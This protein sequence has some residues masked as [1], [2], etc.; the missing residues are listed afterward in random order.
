[1]F[2]LNVLERGVRGIF[3]REFITRQKRAHYTKFCSIVDSD[4]QEEK[5]NMISTLPQLEELKDE[6][7]LSG[8]SEYSYTLANKVYANGVRIPR[9]AIEFDQTGQLR[10]LIQSLAA[11]VANFPDKLVFDLLKN[12][13]SGTCYD[14]TAFFG[15]S[16]DLGDG[17]SQ[18]NLI[19]ANATTDLL[20]ASANSSKADWENALAMVMTDLTRARQALLTL[21]DD[22]GEPWHD[23]LDPAGLLV[24]CGP[25]LEPFF[26]HVVEGTSFLG[27]I[28]NPMV[29]T[30]GQLVVTN[31]DIDTQGDAGDRG[32]WYLMKVDTP[33]QPFIFQRFGPKTQ[34]PDDIPEADMGVIQ[35]L[36][37]VEVQTVMGAGDQ[38]S[39]HTFLN[40]EYL[41]GA[42]VIYSAGY[43][44]WQNCVKVKGSAS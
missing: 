26:R 21:K 27:G 41:F 31:R 40:D 38:T 1:M 14:N 6:R 19:T 39:A 8:F 4:K 13:E 18:S 25:L 17:T 9:T 35:A 2:D 32:T 12:G 33:V 42:R 3:A 22:R 16:H 24:V 7:V 5:Y 37:A 34:F 36:N 15:T 20:E 23:D 30:I 11:R 29:K 10:T 43:G 28:S 44:I